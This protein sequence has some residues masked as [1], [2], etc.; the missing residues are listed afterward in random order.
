M[1]RKP[2][3]ADLDAS[4]R[5]LL[6]A[7]IRNLWTHTS[8]ALEG[9][10]LTLGDTA[11][12]LEEGLTVAGKPLQDHQEVIGHAK[13]IEVVYNLMAK[14][15]IQ[16]KDLFAL[17]RSVLTDAIVDIFKPAGAWKN[18]PN[19]TTYIGEDGRQQFRE[20]PTPR[21][22]PALM[23]Q[24]LQRL[25]GSLRRDLTD[26][27]AAQVY[28]DLHLTFVTIHPFFDG[29]G[30]VARLISNVPVL[31][32]GFPPIVVPTEARQAYKRVI[33]DYQATIPDLGG[34]KDLDTL[35][36]NIERRS[37]MDMCKSYWEPTQTLLKQAQSMQ[38]HLVAGR[39]GGLPGNEALAGTG[40][41]PS[42]PSAR[43]V[44]PKKP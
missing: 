41:L 15:Q 22:T 29:N 26:R 37:F 13:A 4:I 2:F 16:D 12:L 44:R 25:N 17:H 7:Q 21:H 31:H 6:L 30:R 24:W 42:V 8:T 43:P 11:F 23:M 9:N 14:D 18:E 19:F 5:T 35:P 28:A 1:N 36:D 3:Y 10:S 20:F 34:L 39:V 38:Q 27:E 32:A 33:S 40:N